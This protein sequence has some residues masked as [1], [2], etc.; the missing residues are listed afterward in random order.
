MS[1][2]LAIF[3]SSLRDEY[4]HINESQYFRIMAAIDEIKSRG[5]GLTSAERA[6][7]RIFV[8][9][10]WITGMRT[11]EALQLKRKDVNYNVHERM[12]ELTIHTL[13]QRKEVIDM[14]PLDEDY[15]LQLIQFCDAINIKPDDYIFHWRSR[16]M[17]WK[18]VKKLGK[19]C[20]IE[21][22]PK[23]FRHGCAYDIL[24]KTNGNMNMVAKTL[25]HRDIRSTMSYAGLT[26][27][28]ILASQKRR[29]S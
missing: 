5:R 7:M 10:L 19:A 9:T 28:D 15:A 2:E 26:K 14:Q 23:S 18:I 17:A 4:K 21:M 3:N 13:K 11:S 29:R 27:N 6:E 8:K 20:D 24:E 25:R 12:Y 1:N 22:S 16:A